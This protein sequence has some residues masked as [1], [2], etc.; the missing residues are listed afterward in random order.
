MFNFSLIYGE[1]ETSTNVFDKLFGIRG[2]YI[3][4]RADGTY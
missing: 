1:V 4:G 3:R 2:K